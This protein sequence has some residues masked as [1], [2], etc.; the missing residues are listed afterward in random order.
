MTG[1]RNDVK[2]IQRFIYS[3]GADDHRLHLHVS[4]VDPGT[5]AHPPHSH[6]GQEIFYVLSGKGEVIVGETTHILETGEAIQV[7][8]AIE[9]GIKNVG[10]RPM[11]YAVIIARNK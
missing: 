7:D 4:E 2:G 9:H 6:D 1:I 8:C 3:E 11:R 10:E 5:R